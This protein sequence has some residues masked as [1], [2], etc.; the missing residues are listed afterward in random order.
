[1][2]IVS[3]K[4]TVLSVCFVFSLVLLTAW[5]SAYAK[6]GVSNEGATEK[7]FSLDGVQYSKSDLIE[8]LL[9]IA[10][11]EKDWP[12]DDGSDNFHS[13][14]GRLRERPSQTFNGDELFFRDYP[15]LREYIENPRIFSPLGKLYKWHEP[16]NISF[17]WPRYT[18]RTISTP[19]NKL[20]TK[21]FRCARASEDC[22]FITDIVSGKHDEIVHHVARVTSTI[23][24]VTGLDISLRD[25]DSPYEETNNYSR[26]RIVF[27]ESNIQR[28]F[29]KFYRYGKGKESSEWSLQYNEHFLRPAI[30]F[31]VG[32]RSQV[33]GYLVPIKENRLGMSVCKISSAV[34][35]RVM[36][37]LLTECI[38]RS[39][40]LPALSN[41]DRSIFGNWNRAYDP[42][43]FLKELD[44]KIVAIKEIDDATAR[45]A[46]RDF[47]SVK[48]NPEIFS[49]GTEYDMMMLRLLYC[50]KLT[51]GDSREKV[52]DK[53]NNDEECFRDK[54]RN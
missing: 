19:N 13:I 9:L 35:V 38:M 8:D 44:G 41:N 14:Y 53:L 50:G 16:V 11:A 52:R 1:M 51:S 28:N 37:T 6:D 2:S 47:P 26:I 54:K 21:N 49:N 15:W 7:V 42:Y 25:V 22:S 12:E 24:Q 18:L 20:T 23:N 46:S 40:G 27:A 10:F 30:S 33:D 36:K 39:L 31:T 34:E 17:D 4:P 32:T 48:S 45:L 29:F 3:Q 5:C 43:S